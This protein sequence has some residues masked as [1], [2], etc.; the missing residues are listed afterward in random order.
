M[1]EEEIKERLK[2]ST[3]RRLLT[4]DNIYEFSKLVEWLIPFAFE[5]RSLK[6]KNGIELL[7]YIT[8]LFRM[9]DFYFKDDKKES[10]SE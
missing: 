3:Y 1:T 5:H 4:E 10:L 6:P 2:H 7:E 8:E 9:E